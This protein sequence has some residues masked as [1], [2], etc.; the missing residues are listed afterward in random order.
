MNPKLSCPSVF[1]SMCFE[2]CKFGKRIGRRSGVLRAKRERKDAMEP[3][4]QVIEHIRQ[5][6]R[7]TERPGDAFLQASHEGC[8]PGE[9]VAPF[10]GVTDWS[11]LD[12]TILDA[13]YNALSFFSEGGFR[14]FL[15]AYMIADLE[16]LLQTADP[17]FHLT[18][19]FSDEVVKMPEGPRIYEKTIGKSAF[20]NP[21]RYGAMTWHDYARCRLSVFTREEAGAIVAYLEYKRDADPHGL[22]AEKINAALD[23]FWQDRAATAPTHQRVR[24]HLKE[25]ADYLKNIGDGKNG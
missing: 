11:Q 4:Q 22:Y 12:S 5:A 13:S 25:E 9:S 16:D 8:E 6:F 17:V 18:N 24:R 2:R 21:R 10:M 19:G 1:Q 7:E 3:K 23:S 20:V 14:Y 15:P